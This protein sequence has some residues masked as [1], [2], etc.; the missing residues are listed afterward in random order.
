MTGEI[1]F[2]FDDFT[3]TRLLR[4]SFK[5][6]HRIKLD[7]IANEDIAVKNRTKSVASV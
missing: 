6:I 4:L 7:C 3:Q 2:V 1:D 5:I